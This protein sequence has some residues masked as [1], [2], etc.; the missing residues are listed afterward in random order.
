MAINPQIELAAGSGDA[1]R[2]R[3]DEPGSIIASDRF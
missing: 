3:E 1:H 2:G